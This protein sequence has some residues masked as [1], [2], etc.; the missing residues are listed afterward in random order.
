MADNIVCWKCG[1][2]LADLPQPFGR[3]DECRSC[4]AD[5]HVCRMCEFYDTRSNNS[6]REPVAEDVLD[7]ERSNFCGYYKARPGTYTDQK[8]KVAEQARDELESLFGGTGEGG[9]VDTRSD[10]DKA[11]EALEDLFSPGKG[12]DKNEQ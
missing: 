1:A 11:R 3:R 10:A 5:L 8:D 6:C 7:K 4:K 12:V 2:D 9:S